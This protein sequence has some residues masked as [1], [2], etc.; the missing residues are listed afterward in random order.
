METELKRW[1]FLA[2][3]AFATCVVLAAALAEA[4]L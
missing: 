4:V 1:R 3:L 2:G